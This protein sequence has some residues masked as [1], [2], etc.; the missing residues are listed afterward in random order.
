ML[1]L[2]GGVASPRRGGAAT[3]GERTMRHVRRGGS[4]ETARGVRRDRREVE[5]SA[6]RVR[7]PIWACSPPHVTAHFS[8][9]VQGQVCG[10][11]EHQL[12]VASGVQGSRPL[13]AGHLHQVPAQRAHPE[14]P[15][16]P[17]RGH[18]DWFRSLHVWR[19]VKEECGSRWV[20]GWTE[21]HG[22][23][24]VRRCIVWVSRCATR[25]VS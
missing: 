12:P 16:L 17:A 14:P 19:V 20:C 2:I 11:G 3:G 18:G 15:G 25:A 9:S 24:T 4:A 21:T 5:Q 13:A 10:P 8:F 22:D 7:A 1:R 6:A 23:A